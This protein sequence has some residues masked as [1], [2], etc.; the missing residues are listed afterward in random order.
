MI[1]FPAHELYPFKVPF[2]FLFMRVKY[3]LTYVTRPFASAKLWFILS[4]SQH[5]RLFVTQFGNQHVRRILV[6]NFYLVL[7]EPCPRQ[8]KRTSHEIYLTLWAMMR[9]KCAN[10][11]RSSRHEMNEKRAAYVTDTSFFESWSEKSEL[12]MLYTSFLSHKTKKA[13]HT[14][15]K[16]WSLSHEAKQ[17]RHTSDIPRSLRHEERQ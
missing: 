9:N 6:A 5:R 7:S 3:I 12:H 15:N 1:S 14:S 8:N 16:P 4:S 13:R 17:V 10:V 11:H 2:A